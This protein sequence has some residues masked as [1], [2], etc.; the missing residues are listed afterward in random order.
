MERIGKGKT[1]PK[2]GRMTE[3]ERRTKAFKREI[4]NLCR[5]SEYGNLK[6]VTNALG[7]NYNSVYSLLNNGRIRA[8][9]V[10]Q[11]FKATGA[12]DK[13]ILKLMRM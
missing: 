7:M 1:M 12:D 11:I 6:A 13:T 2:V 3:E 4:I 10:G 5:A 9:T 8:H